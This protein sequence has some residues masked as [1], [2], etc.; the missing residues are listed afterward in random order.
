MY[1]MDIS[2]TARQLTIEQYQLDQ[3]SPEPQF[4]SVTRMV[5][6]LFDVR[7][8]AVTVLRRDR[9]L[10]ISSVG[11]DGHETA[12][13]D[14]FCN[15]TVQGTE[16]FVVEDALQDPRFRNNPLVTGKPYIR[17]YAGAPIRIGKDIPIG[18][19]CLIDREPRQF[20]ETD[21]HQLKQMAT[22]LAGIMEL[23]IGSR[24]SEQRKNE[25]Q[26]QAELLRS[27]IDNVPQGIAL[28]DPQGQL[29][30]TNEQLFS[31]LNLSGE[32]FAYRNATAH[33]LLTNA[34]SSGSFGPVD[35]E[36]FIADLISSAPHTSHNL[37]EL[38]DLEGRFLEVRYTWI[39]GGRSILTVDDVSERHK[40]V[41]L[42]DEFISTASHELRTP[43]TSIRGALAI[44]GRKSEESFD[45][46]GRQMLNMAS[47]NAE[48][49]TDLVNDILDIEKLGSA[50]MSMRSEQVDFGQVL[51]DSCNQIRPYAI[52]HNVVVSLSADE[53]LLVLGDAGRL[54]QA[55]TNLL[56]NACKFSPAG[57]EVKVVG[58]MQAGKVNV[59]VSDQGKGIP[60]EF[61]EQIFRRF[62]QADAQHR[63]GVAGSGLGLAITKA[64][65]EQHQGEIGYDSEL[66]VGTRFWISLPEFLPD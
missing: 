13:E 11:I 31:L 57:S 63:S 35:S 49:L 41:R 8:S 62:A 56:S 64:I 6:N 21:R 24:L 66:G 9:Q 58:E 43:L 30:L 27:T 22:V 47:R 48:R 39:E 25:A 59:T 54:Q 42:K 14:A 51:R 5:S 61:R 50:E 55:I 28:I 4:D 20:S 10:F 7:M 1:D 16:V 36:K 18:A 29:I 2:E 40:L 12:R 53:A 23:R 15:V 33:T 44:L 38:R 26:A 65:V 46:Q 32:S 19:L 34:V 60:A 3:V 37:A 52:S 17:F 45:A